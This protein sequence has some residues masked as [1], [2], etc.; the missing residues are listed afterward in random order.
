MTC[1]HL[2][3]PATPTMLRIAPQLGVLAVLDEVLITTVCTL[4]AQHPSLGAARA[5][6]SP[7][8]E[9]PARRLYDCLAHCSH[10]L[11]DYRLAVAEMVTTLDEASISPGGHDIPF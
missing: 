11:A 1:R 8:D 7:P 5:N 6:D 3:V 2:D 9:S 10:V 4:V